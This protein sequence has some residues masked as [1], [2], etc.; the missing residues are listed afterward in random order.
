[1]RSIKE[2]IENSVFNYFKENNIRSGSRI[3]AAYSGG[4]DSTALLYILSNLSGFNLQLTAAYYNHCLRSRE[5]LQREIEHIRIQTERLGIPLFV[6]SAEEGTIRTAASENGLSL[7][8][9]ARN[10]RYTFFYSTAEQA[11]AQYIATGHNINDNT[12][13]MIMRF[14]QN[15]GTAGLA[16]IP[17]RRKQIIRPLLKVN[18]KDIELFLSE[19][20]IFFSTD[21]SN[22]EVD[23]LRN[24]VRHDLIP[25]VREIFPD[26]D[27]N[28]SALSE[29]MKLQ[30][31][32]IDSETE[33]RVVWEKTG[34]GW[35]IRTEAFYAEPLLLRIKSIYRILNLVSSASRINYKSVMQAAGGPGHENGKVLLKNADTEVFT[36]NGYIFIERLVNHEK[37]SYLLNM[38]T[39]VKVSA[40]RQEFLLRN[41]DDFYVSDGK[42]DEY[43]IE[44]KS[45]NPLI[46]RSAREGDS[47]EMDFGKKSLKKLFNEWKVRPEDK[48]R[49]PVVEDAGRIVAVIGRHLGY[50]NKTAADR[51]ENGG[52]LEKILLVNCSDT[53]TIGE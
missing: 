11:D 12:E 34:R 27:S 49:V 26:I 30:N 28:M 46:V 40:L 39:G 15:S 37:K 35:K 18:R 43:L 20:K 45:R 6:G 44:I 23:Y 33:K 17:S 8:E 3:I 4:P 19:E 42:E 36:R 51:P 50:D 2:I 31:D 1:M 52:G 7:E 5:E 21:T 41:A 29:K 24:K 10:A 53:E 25:A 9:A 38:E 22:F 14:M 16:G 48:Y 13:T 32:F 47:I